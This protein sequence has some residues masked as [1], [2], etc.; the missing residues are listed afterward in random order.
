M[1]YKSAALK[2]AEADVT[3]LRGRGHGLDQEINNEIREQVL[4]KLKELRTN[5]HLTAKEYAMMLLTY[6]R[7]QY[8]FVSLR[9]EGGLAPNAGASVRKYE[10]A[11]KTNDARRRAANARSAEPDPELPQP[12]DGF[13]PGIFDDDDT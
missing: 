2:M 3:H 7:I 5:E 8:I 11:F 12:D 4:I 13:D 1:A 9:K 10:S 6:T